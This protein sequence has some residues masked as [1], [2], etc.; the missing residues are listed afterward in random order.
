MCL[1]EVLEVTS[2]ATVAETGSGHQGRRW[3]QGE[4]LQDLNWSG[5]QQL[6]VPPWGFLWLASVGFSYREVLSDL[7]KYVRCKTRRRKPLWSES[8]EVGLEEL[9]IPSGSNTFR[10]TDGS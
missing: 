1:Q 6:P 3:R 7:G 9:C 5:G 8:G 2:V 10:K 4:Q